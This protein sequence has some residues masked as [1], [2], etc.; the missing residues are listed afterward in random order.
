MQITVKG[1]REMVV[2]FLYPLELTIDSGAREKVKRL[3]WVSWD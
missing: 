1:K 3:H 2:L